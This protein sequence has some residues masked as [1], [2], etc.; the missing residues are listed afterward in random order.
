MGLLS[1]LF[2][3]AVGETVKGIGEGVSTLA[4][5][6]RSAITGELSAD[7]RA[8]LEKMAIEADK[9]YQKSQTEINKIEAQHASIFIAG[10]RPFI[11]W[12]C[13][14]ALGFNFILNPL[15]V[16]VSKIF[17]KDVTPPMLDMSEL[18]PLVLALLGLGVYRTYEKARS[19]Q[20]KH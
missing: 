2:A 6:I 16:W 17:A 1:K 5:G 19:V 12:I 20:H 4:T 3:P 7:K 9:L 18:Y 8:E 13:G 15:I 10:W 14:L 11:G